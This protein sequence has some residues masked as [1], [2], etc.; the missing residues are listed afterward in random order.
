MLLNIY[1]EAKHATKPCFPT[2]NLLALLFDEI[3]YSVGGEGGPGF[4]SAM[5]LFIFGKANRP[6]LSASGWGLKRDTQRLADATR[7]KIPLNILMEFAEDHRKAMVNV[8]HR[9]V[10]V[11][12]H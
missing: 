12:W 4:V 1:V 5:K 11:L 8:S 10:L 9:L 6:T 7:G 3:R 2:N